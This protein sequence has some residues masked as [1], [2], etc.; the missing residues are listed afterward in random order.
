[1]NYGRCRRFPAGSLVLDIRECS[2][3]GGWELH[4]RRD[5]E[6]DWR[7]G[8]V[9]TSRPGQPDTRLWSVVVA[10]TMGLLVVGLVLFLLTIFLP[11]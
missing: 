10:V 2:G 11:E 3:P 1:M 5:I 9:D 7:D 4:P 8:E 6:P